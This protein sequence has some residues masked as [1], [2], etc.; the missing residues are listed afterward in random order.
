MQGAML[1]LMS[2][3]N[4]ISARPWSSLAPAEQGPR[5]PAPRRPATFR[6]FAAGAVGESLRRA[7][8]RPGGR[9]PEKTFR[10]LS[11][12]Y[13]P[14]AQCYSCFT[15]PVGQGRSRRRDNSRGGAKFR[16]KSAGGGPAEQ[17]DD[18]LLG[19]AGAPLGYKHKL[20]QK[21]EPDPKRR[22]LRLQDSTTQDEARCIGLA[23]NVED[24]YGFV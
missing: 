15:P 3:T 6:D 20:M 14:D 13:P 1:P 2:T 5:R 10:W 17:H 8:D 12:T 24:P 9:T 16:K 23:R 4:T 21:L 18:G 22:R 7:S 19:Q 11:E